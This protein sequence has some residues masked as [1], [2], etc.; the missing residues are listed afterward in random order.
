MMVASCVRRQS[1]AERTA[2]PLPNPGLPS[3]HH[4]L[5]SDFPSTS[6]RLAAYSFSSQT[7]EQALHLA[8]TMV[9]LQSFLLITLFSV[10]CIVGPVF[11][12][13]DPSD[14]GADL[15]AEITSLADK[16]KTKNT[17]ALPSG[18]IPDACSNDCPSDAVTQ[19]TNC[20]ADACPCT[21]ALDTSISTCMACVVREGAISTDLGKA[22]STQYQ[23]IC[24]M[25]GVNLASIQNANGATMITV[26][27][28]A[29][30]AIVGAITFL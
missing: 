29:L 6:G 18:S 10:L 11:A 13:V 24:K 15:F 22:V 21:D 26:G 5:N 2:R 7:Q 1:Y 27:L 23:S 28:P 4:S 19:I 9:S 14:T 16:S 3:S 25:R 30:L 12:Q 8:G 20:T 17:T